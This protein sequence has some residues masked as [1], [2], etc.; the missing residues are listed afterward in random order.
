[1]P[2]STHGRAVFL[3]SLA[4][5][6]SATSARICDPM[7]PELAR[8]LNASLSETSRVMS[9][10]TVAYGLVQVLFG[11]IGD[12]YGKYRLVAYATLACTVT[13]LFAAASPTLDWL[14]LARL[15]TGVSA[16]A[17][18]PLSMAWIGDMIPYEQRQATLAR[19][20]SGQIFGIVG[21]QFVGGLFAD[22]LG[23]RW[24][25][26]FLAGVYILIGGL[27]LAESRRN[28]STH[29]TSSTDSG[30]LLRQI[31]HVLGIGWARFILATVAI[32]GFFV[33]G[34]LSFLPSYLHKA[35]GMS[36]TSAGATLLFF[37][38]G[39][40]TYAFFARHFV[41]RLGE[42]GLALVGGSLIALAWLILITQTTWYWALPI[43][44][45]V[46][47]GYYMMHNTLQTNA[48]QMSPAHRGTAVSMFASTFFL[49]QS[50][51]ISAAA[52]LLQHTD[53]QW[54]FIWAA[55]GVPVVGGVFAAGLRRKPQH[56]VAK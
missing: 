49:G 21:G 39:G 1:M 50:A 25:F 19:F 13:S 17:I 11:T 44:F 35:Y 3:L 22:T 12:R 45:C 34:S 26:V 48:T 23:W 51:G 52:W 27:V 14:I 7:L 18:I 4:A 54:I 37:G 47:L 38:V 20:I 46:G 55:I 24:V 53:A 56:A 28:E 29:H 10:F 43:T 5:F 6:A 16:A 42:R 40:L 30:G 2:S 36:L 8:S 41:H 31:G 33:F 32:E 15:L 9:A